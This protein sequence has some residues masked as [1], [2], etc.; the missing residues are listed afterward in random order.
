[1]KKS[2]GQTKLGKALGRVQFASQKNWFDQI[3]SK[4]DYNVV[5]LLVSYVARETVQITC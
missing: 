1:M 5:V 3:V 2:R 4:L